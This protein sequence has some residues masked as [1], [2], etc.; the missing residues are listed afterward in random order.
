VDEG[1]KKDE[2]Q[3]IGSRERRGGVV[4]MC[5]MREE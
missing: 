1:E 2:E 3:G 5:S 4:R